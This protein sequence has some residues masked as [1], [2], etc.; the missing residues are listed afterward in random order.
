[1]HQ[2][3]CGLLLMIKPGRVAS[4]PN[5]VPERPGA[6]P[7]PVALPCSLTLLLTV[8]RKTDEAEGAADAR[9]I[10][11][12]HPRHLWPPTPKLPAWL[13]ASDAAA[14]TSAMFR[15]D[16][17]SYALAGCPNSANPNAVS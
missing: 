6:V 5:V 11:I 17:V 13:D 10:P 12:R 3:Q 8:R 14:F 9:S 1:M 7:Q 16:S 2:C 4:F 15:A